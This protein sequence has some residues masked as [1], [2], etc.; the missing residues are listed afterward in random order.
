MVATDP[1]LIRQNEEFNKALD[2]CHKAGIG[3]ISMKQGRGTENGGVYLNL[4]HLPREQI[5]RRIPGT[6]DKFRAFG[7]ACARRPWS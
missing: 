7:Y 3:L 6:L 5:E 2:A 1:I 4:S